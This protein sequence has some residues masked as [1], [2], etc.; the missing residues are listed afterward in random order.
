M[1]HLEKKIVKS[2]LQW[3]QNY[4][5]GFQG[6]LLPSLLGKAILRSSIPHLWLTPCQAGPS[7]PPPTCDTTVLPF[8]GLHQFP[9]LGYCK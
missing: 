3:Q 2:L 5:L 1:F 9:Y 8:P 4:L 7:T 6:P